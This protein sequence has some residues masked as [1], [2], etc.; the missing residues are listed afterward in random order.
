MAGH[1]LRKNLLKRSQEEQVQE[2]NEM[3]QGATET[4]VPTELQCEAERS[5]LK[6]AVTNVGA[7]KQGTTIP[8]DT[9]SQVSKQSTNPSLRRETVSTHAQDEKTSAVSTNERHTFGNLADFLLRAPRRGGKWSLEFF[10][11]VEL[12]GSNI[13]VQE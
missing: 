3:H 13:Q 4:T 6:A 2:V 5:S 11:Q 10:K 8:R 1:V 9:R 12:N 7:G